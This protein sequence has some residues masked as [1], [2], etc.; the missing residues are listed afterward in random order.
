LGF[1][2]LERVVVADVCASP[3]PLVVACGGG[4]VVDP[5]NRRAL[6]RA[7]LV[8]WLRA[9]VAT[10]LDRVGDPSDRP[11]LRDDPEGALLRLGRLREMT[12]EAAS[13][14]SVETDGLDV[15]AVADAVLSVFEGAAA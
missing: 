9:P 13:H 2:A 4:T 14:A 15:A 5:D 10:L 12:Y 8:V 6:R 7:G 1:R 3:E 11:L